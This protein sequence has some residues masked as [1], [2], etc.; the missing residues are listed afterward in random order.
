ML[1]VQGYGATS[2]AAELHNG[3]AKL[4]RDHGRH[5]VASNMSSSWE[6]C[7]P[8]SCRWSRCYSLNGLGDMPQPAQRIRFCKSHDGIRIAFAVSGN[9][10]PILKAAHWGTHIDQT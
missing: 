5:A 6:R 8:H 3:L 9:G 4:A 7:S 10:L 1:V 2:H